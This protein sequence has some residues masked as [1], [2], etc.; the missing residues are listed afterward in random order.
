MIEWHHQPNGH[1]FEQTPGDSVGQGNLACCSPW[2]CKESDT[3][4]WLNNNEHPDWHNIMPK[5]LSHWILV[6][7]KSDGIHHQVNEEKLLSQGVFPANEQ[8]ITLVPAEIYYVH[9]QAYLAASKLW[10]MRCKG[11][12]EIRN[13]SVTHTQSSSDFKISCL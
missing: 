8:G 9:P 5:W 6:F 12:S 10:S 4:H 7:R 2:G 13:H 11:I 3:T 1:E